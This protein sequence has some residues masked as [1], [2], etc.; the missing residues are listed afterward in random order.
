[1]HLGFDAAY[2]VVANGS[3]TFGLGAFLRYAAANAD[4]PVVSG[5]VETDLGGYQFGAGVRFRF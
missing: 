3:S 1:M 4:L 5:T 2:T